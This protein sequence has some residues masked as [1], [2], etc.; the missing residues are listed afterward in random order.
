MINQDQEITHLQEP[1]AQH[2]NNI[3]KLEKQLAIHAAGEAPVH[4]LKK[5]E[6][7]Q[8]QLR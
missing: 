7:E 3:R 2:R 1:Q 8:Q 4:L 6:S 5:L